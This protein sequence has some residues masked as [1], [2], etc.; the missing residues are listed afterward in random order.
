MFFAMLKESPG[1]RIS[2][3]YAIG[4]KQQKYNVVTGVFLGA[5]NKQMRLIDLPHNFS[6]FL[7]FVLKNAHAYI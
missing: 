2:I 4:I 1:K 5:L 3:G 7:R 6:L